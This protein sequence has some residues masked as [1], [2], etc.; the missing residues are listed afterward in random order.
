MF[1]LVV[2]LNEI[3]L[4]LFQL[5]LQILCSVGLQIYHQEWSHANNEM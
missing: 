2:H 3:S 1:K 5:W 4:I